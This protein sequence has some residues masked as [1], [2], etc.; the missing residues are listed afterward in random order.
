MHEFPEVQAMLRQV[1]SQTPGDARITRMTFLVG[2]ASGHDSH[3][4]AAHFVEAARGSRAEGAVLEFRLERLAAKCAVCGTE[5]GPREKA[6]TCTHCGAFELI[7]TAGNRV[8]L[9]G[10]ETEPSGD[11]VIR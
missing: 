4:I 8:A 2:E 7:I 3:H 11:R 5:F 9:D 10:F 1:L 6:L